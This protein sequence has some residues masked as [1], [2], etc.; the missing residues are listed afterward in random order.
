VLSQ[1][2]EERQKIKD[3]GVISLIDK[4]QIV[5]IAKKE[6]ELFLATKT[7]PNPSLL[8]RGIDQSSPLTK[9]EIEQSSTLTRRG[10]DQSSALTKKEIDQSS[11]LTKKEIDQTSTITRREIDQSSTITRREIEQSSTLTRGRQEGV[12]QKILLD[13]SSLELKLIQKI[14]DEAHRS[15]ITFNRDT[16]VK[17]SKKNILESLP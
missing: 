7:S 9:K 5:S 16:R 14:R 13:K 17:S 1:I 15:A 8:R 2:K 4:L 12:F 10:I 11:T 3:V 6:E